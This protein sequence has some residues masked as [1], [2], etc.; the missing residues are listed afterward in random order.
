MKT[1]AR[2]EW[3]FDGYITSDCGA[4]NDV[5]FA[6]NFTKTPE[7]SAAAIL[8][9]GQDVDCSE[10]TKT[11]TPKALAQNLI[12]QEDIDSRIRNLFRV[13]F[14]LGH[15]DPP[16]PM[17]ALGAKDIC[18][19]YAVELARDGATQGAVLIKNA[20]SRL[21]LSAAKAGTVAVIGP[22]ANLSSLDSGYY[23]PA[24]PC[25]V[26]Q[27]PNLVSAI[28]NHAQSTVTTLAMNGPN[29]NS[30]SG[31][32]AAVA[33]AAGAD[34]VVLALGT[35][36]YTA[37][38]GHDAISI[39]L[40]PAQTELLTKV[41]AASKSPVIVV[42]L[43]ATPL[44]ISSMM[45]DAKVGAVLSIGQPSVNMLGIGDLLFGLRSP[46]GRMIQTIYPASYQSAVS[47]FDFHM[48]PGQ[49]EYPRP[50]CALQPQ[51]RCPRGTNP[52]RTHRF[53]NGSAVV[54]FGAGL[55]YTTWNY[56]TARQ[57]G[58]EKAAVSVAPVHQM[59]VDSAGRS[60]PSITM[61]EAMAPLVS[62]TVNVSNTGS[63]DADDV[64][65]GFMR[66]PGA[67][68]NGIPLQTLFG[69]ER[70]HVKAGQTVSVSLFPS[71]L[72]FTQA[73]SEGKRYAL[74][75]EYQF[76]FGVGVEGW[77]H[78]AGMGYT[79]HQLIVEPAIE[80]VAPVRTAHAERRSSLKTDDGSLSP[81]A[82]EGRLFGVWSTDPAVAQLRYLRG[83]QAVVQWADVQEQP[84]TFNFSSLDAAIVTAIASLPASRDPRFTIQVNGNLHPRF[85]FEHVPFLPSDNSWS[86]E[87]QDPCPEDIV[88]APP[89]GTKSCVL[90]FWHLFFIDQYTK[91]LKALAEHLAKQS[92]AS[93]LLGLRQNFDAVGT[94]GTG[95]PF[96][97]RN[98][99][100]WVIPKGVTP[101]A[102]FN[103]VPGAEGTQLQY[104]KRV[105]AAHVSSFVGGPVRLL[106]RNNLDQQIRD[107]HLT[108]SD[109]A[110]F[111]VKTYGELM[112]RG[113]VGWFHTSSEM[114]PRLYGNGKSGD[115][116][117]YMT[118]A[119]DCARTVCYAEPWADAWGFHGRR[120][121]R[122]CSPPQW[123]YW[124]LLSDLQMGVSNIAIYG[125]DA[126]VA[127]DGTHMKEEVGARYQQEFGAALEFAASY[128]GHWAKPQ[129]AP[130][131]WVAF[132]ESV[133]P[134]GSYSNVTDYEFHMRLVN[135]VDATIGL[136]ARTAGAP[137]PAVA[138]RTLG[139]ESSIGPP[140][141]RYGAWAR[142]L[143]AGV[144]AELELATGLQV[145][146]R[147]NSGVV[148]ASVIYLD[149]C[150]GATLK[151]C[152]GGECQSAAVGNSGEWKT[153]HAGKLQLRSVDGNEEAAPRLAL[154]AVG[155]DVIVHMV[156]VRFGGDAL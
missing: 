73:D 140:D 118:F 23:G 42:M 45:N 21:P 133:T 156:Q 142:Q 65:L 144:A 70:V 24:D 44:D 26:Q 55:S 27:W 77:S 138:N 37:G 13:R 71:L 91:M 98:N 60:S 7:E 121:S 40:T 49:S 117:Q 47:I 31:I 136:D 69:F 150:A 154:T 135:P 113:M 102:P 80:P 128:V 149:A 125:N 19:D 127:A 103:G 112:A 66:P 97:L 4:S 93:H 105:F 96:D 148:N 114:E 16:G 3:S 152:G 35:D 22:N 50:D 115:W 8:K 95:I 123:V 5:F 9:A 139:N 143:K 6:H 12:T 74:P 83:G 146:A 106:A 72:D 75:G 129:T 147:A 30:T 130:G 34:T 61:V 14:R 38:E 81:S 56:S 1:L 94:E 134:L 53:Y 101:A 63:M 90:Q 18:S 116:P 89:E 87:C 88:P 54:P 78:T 46:A 86:A 132:R 59:L 32:P 79:E 25:Q 43:T 109:A 57:D 82:D 48:R 20:A 119:R 2:D 100:L 11:Y 141:S 92:Y 41:S 28:A 76:R 62:W 64:V 39:S 52:G 108:G 104:T 68:E 145:W 153:L 51:S 110:R 131:A 122:W 124:R 84:D 29:S 137:V 36:T 58:D 10:F 85:L 155:G 15:F 111:G 120:D 107:A 126:S 99:S 151:L 17:H 67:G 33:M